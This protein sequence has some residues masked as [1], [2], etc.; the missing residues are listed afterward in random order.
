[1]VCSAKKF[2][3]PYGIVEIDEN[4]EIDTMREKPSMTFLT[5]TGCYIVEPEVINDLEENVPVGFPDIIERYKKCG[6]K[7]GVYPISENAWLDMG[8][9]DEWGKMEVTL[10]DEQ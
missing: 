8:Q 3:I 10:S 9:V 7:V 4:G 5:N 6:K 1:M 2:T